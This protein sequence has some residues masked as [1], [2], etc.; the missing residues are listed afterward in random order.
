MSAAA[1]RAG[2]E[3]RD[4]RT[5]LTHDYTRRHGIDSWIQA[6]AGAPSW[7]YDREDLWN[8]VEAREPQKNSQLARE[9]NV[10]LPVEL[11]RERQDELVRGYVR[12]QFTSRGMV[13]DV[14]VHRDKEENPHAHVMLTM[15]RV[16]GDSFGPKERDWNRKDLLEGW[17]ESWSTH[18]N[19]ALEREGR[20]ERIDH[21]SFA[22][23]GID[24]EPTVHEGPNVREMERRGIPTERGEWN[25]AVIE[26]NAERDRRDDEAR[27]EREREEAR[28]RDPVER[29]V[30]AW[31]SIGYSR[32]TARTLATWERERGAEFHTDGEAH[33][34]LERQRDAMY[35]DKW[36]LRED[37]HA[38][39]E[40]DRMLEARDRALE[41]VAEH[42]T[43]G[44]VLRRAFSGSAREDY[45]EARRDVGWY[46]R[47]LGRQGIRGRED[48]DRR[49]EELSAREEAQREREGSW[50][51][52]EKAWRELGSVMRAREEDHRQEL[53]ER[54]WEMLDR[55]RGDA[56]GTAK[57]R[58]EMDRGDEWGR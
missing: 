10:A 45:R 28:R 2:E 48:L 33:Q 39:R 57:A 9:I 58:E 37:G 26:R 29:R 30:D 47:E 51:P 24:R 50:G 6:P 31:R 14:A 54:N 4:E 52:Y 42:E 12:E 49:A 16:D 7:V 25:R 32:E 18:A 35:R 38:L 13:A 3:L 17:R 19:R 8:R 34:Q 55:M 20:E 27:R 56:P 36:S 53:R 22:E 44:G 5:G 11:G 15:R 41:K 21:R 46:D 23:R 43:G 1:Y 40:V